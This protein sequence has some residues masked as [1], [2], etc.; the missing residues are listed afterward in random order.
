MRRRAQLA[1]AAALALGAAR[2][3]AAQGDPALRT[4]WPV[5]TAVLAGSLGLVGLAHLIAIDPARRWE[6]ELLPLDE[7]VKR[8][9]SPRAAR[10]SDVLVGTT[11]AAP[12]ALQLAG[13]FDQAS[14]ERALVYGEVLAAN[15]ALNGVVKALVNRPRPFTYN[16]DPGARALA[17]RDPRDARLSF[18]SGHASTAFA[19]AVGGAYLFSQSTTDTRARAAVWAGSLMLAGATSHLRVRAGKHFYSDVLTG[20]VIGAGVGWL[21]PALHFGGR[22]PN[23]LSPGEWVAIAAAPAAGVLVSHLLPLEATEKVVAGARVVPWV[24]PRGAGLVLA[25]LF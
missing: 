2:P 15:L 20:A 21:V 9:F 6:R 12:L 4:D 7:G 14:G 1:L 13:G 16:T 22:G 24:T 23:P 18:Y 5:E 25:G 17:E 19:A 8:N 11:V 3:A 10:W